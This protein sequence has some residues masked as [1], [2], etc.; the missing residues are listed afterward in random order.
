M[1]FLCEHKAVAD[2]WYQAVSGINSGDSGD[3]DSV[4]RNVAM[5]LKKRRKDNKLES[6]QV[7]ELE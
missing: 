4:P 2:I 6:L 1:H 5:P 7:N 3:G